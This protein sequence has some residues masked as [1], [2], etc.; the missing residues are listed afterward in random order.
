MKKVITAI[1]ISLV[2]LLFLSACSSKIDNK[3]TFQNFASN[4]VHVNFRATLITVEAGKS[5][6]ITEIARGQYSYQTTYEVPSGT[7]TSKEVGDVSGTVE[8]NSSTKILI[9]YSST[10]VEGTY[11]I[12]ATKT[13]SDEQSGGGGDPIGP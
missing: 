12:G 4:A 3:I 6:E 13:S 11:T 2:L 8:L 7:T 1:N 9:V 5:V 10:F